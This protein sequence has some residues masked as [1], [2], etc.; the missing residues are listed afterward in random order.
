MKDDALNGNSILDDKHIG[1][2]L[3]KLS[4]PAFIGMLVMSLYNIVDT[5]FVGHYVGHLG[6]AGL[7]ISFPLQMLCMGIG[8]LVGIGGASLVSRQLGAGDGEGAERT[9]GNSFLIMFVFSIAIVVIGYWDPDRWL[10]LMGASTGILPYART[11]MI[12]ILVGLPFQISAMALNGLVRSEGNAVAPMIGMIIGAASN[13]V[14]DAVFIVWLGMGIKGAAIATTIAQILSTTYLISYYLFPKSFVKARLSRLRPDPAIL[15]GIFLIGI[16]SFARTIATSIMIVITNNML[17]HY[18][19][20]VAVSALGILFRVMIFALMPGI[21]IGQGL[22]P[23]L[24]FNYGARRYDMALSSI[25][26]A[27]FYATAMCTLVFLF[28]YFNPDLIIR[29]F[30]SDTEVISTGVRA[31]RFVFLPIFMIG[32][33]MVGSLTFQAIGKPVQSFFTSAS[34]TLLFMIP[35]LFILPGLYG[36]D[37]V[38]LAF[39]LADTLTFL[40]TAALFIP[41]VHELRRLHRLNPR[42]AA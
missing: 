16:A 30:I 1:R 40:L 2:L 13:I 42:P 28:V 38:W 29:A 20:D 18:G 10:I 32:F 25:R 33:L 17:V 12:F 21:A 35:L 8:Q 5:F 6:I 24:G 37:G 23:I 22:Q 3:L 15:G 41:Q 9:L 27:L 26:I 39:P 34:R 19:G 11:Y 36:L 14:L 7:S 31:S 4:L